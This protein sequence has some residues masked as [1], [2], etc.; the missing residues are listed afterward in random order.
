MQAAESEKCHFCPWWPWLLTLT[1]N[2]VRAKDQTRLPCDFGTNP[3]SGSRDISY[4]DKE[5]Q[6]DGAKKNSINFC[7]SLRVVKTFL[8]LCKLLHYFQLIF[9]Q[10]SSPKWSNDVLTWNLTVSCSQWT[11]LQS[12]QAFQNHV[13]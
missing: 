4:T 6:T 10:D 3:F 8:R 9:Q 7:R 1:F 11:V 2:L 5:T 13:I 12:M